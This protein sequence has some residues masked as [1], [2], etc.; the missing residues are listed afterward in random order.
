M[1]APAYAFLML[2]CAEVMGLLRGKMV[3]GVLSAVLGSC[4]DIRETPSTGNPVTHAVLV[5]PP[6]HTALRPTAAPA[7]LV[8]ELGGQA[9]CQGLHQPHPRALGAA[10]RP[11]APLHLWPW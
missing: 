1:E 5:L 10:R 7:G 3:L 9:Q 2:M 6:R 11:A 4:E 8:A